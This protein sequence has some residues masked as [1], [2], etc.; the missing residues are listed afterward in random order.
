MFSFIIVD[1]KPFL[2]LSQVSLH[3]STFCIIGI[4]KA[5]WKTHLQQFLR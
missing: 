3:I 5:I 4:N 1:E 2:L